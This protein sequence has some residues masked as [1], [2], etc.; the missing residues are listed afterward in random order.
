MFVLIFRNQTRSV[1][2]LNHRVKQRQSAYCQHI[3]FKTDDSGVRVA[4]ETRLTPVSSSQRFEW[5]TSG[6]V[7]VCQYVCTVEYVQ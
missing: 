3:V 7:N 4:T 6:V 2:S 1:I 5:G